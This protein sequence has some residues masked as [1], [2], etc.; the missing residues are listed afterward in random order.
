MSVQIE[1]IEDIVEKFQARDIE[2]IRPYI[3]KDFTWF[4]PSGSVVMQGADI[5]LGAITS[6]WREN[7]DVKNESSVCIQVGNLVSHTETFTGY[8]DGHIEEWIWVY[9]FLGSQILKMY[10]F[11]NAD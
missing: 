4:D 1:A 3:H 7:P 8:P 5:F 6:T 10:G 2:A 9:E 11:K